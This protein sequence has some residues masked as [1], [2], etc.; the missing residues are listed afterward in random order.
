MADVERVR[1]LSANHF[2]M[3]V[4]PVSVSGV[5][6]ILSEPGRWSLRG[7][8]ERVGTDVQPLVGLTVMWLV[9]AG[10]ARIRRDG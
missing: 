2:G 10:I 5:W 9:K 1:S 6:S 7:I 3:A 4:N 8:R